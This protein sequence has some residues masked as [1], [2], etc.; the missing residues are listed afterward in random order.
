MNLYENPRNGAATL[1][2][3]KGQASRMPEES[4]SKYLRGLEEEEEKP[5]PAKKRWVE[6]NPRVRE[7][8]SSL[9]CIGEKI[10]DGRGWLYA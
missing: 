5:F 6:A 1:P 3:A 9:I 10:R 8:V 2:V 4:P 7:R